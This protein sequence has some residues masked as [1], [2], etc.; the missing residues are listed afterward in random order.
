MQAIKFLLI[1]FL[2]GVANVAFANSGCAV[3]EGGV[4]NYEGNAEQMVAFIQKTAENI[5]RSAE[6]IHFEEHEFYSDPENRNQVF[7]FDYL[8]SEGIIVPQDYGGRR[9]YMFH[10]GKFW[11]F[12][13]PNAVGVM[14]DCDSN[15]SCGLNAII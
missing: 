3:G 2:V 12:Y 7:N 8:L 13:L 6:Y 5:Q 10:F 15:K 4:S 14:K 9:T 11:V 1:F